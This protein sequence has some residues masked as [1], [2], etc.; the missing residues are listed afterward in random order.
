MNPI[1]LPFHDYHIPEIK[2]K[3]KRLTIRHDPRHDF[4]PGDKLVFVDYKTHIFGYARVVS[5]YTMSVKEIIATHWKH[6][7]NYNCLEDFRVK[8]K[9]FYPKV[10]FE[11]QTEL[12][13]IEW[14]QTF[15]PNHIYD[16]EK[17]T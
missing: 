1:V 9:A 13:V 2:E 4:R 5:A 10:E 17:K 11:P 14:G 7:G 16:F 15:D 12:M 8:F 6:H 3:E